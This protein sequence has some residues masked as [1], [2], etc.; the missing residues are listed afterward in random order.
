MIKVH[1]DDLE[2]RSWVTDYG[3]YD[4]HHGNFVGFPKSYAK[5]EKEL[6]ALRSVESIVFIIYKP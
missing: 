6:T 3:I 2:V 1:I 4:K 5:C